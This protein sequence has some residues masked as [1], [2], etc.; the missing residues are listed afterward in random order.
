MYSRHGAARLYIL[1]LLLALLAPASAHAFKA[2][3]HD[4]A[5]LG[6]VDVR[7]DDRARPSA[8]AG[9]ARSVLESLLG[10]EGD[11]RSDR[12]TGALSFIGRTDGFLT[13]PSARSPAEVVL[14][15]LRGHPAS[16]GLDADDIDALELG[17][18]DVS[19]DGSTHLRWVQVVDGIRSLDSGV[20]AHVDTRGRLIS[21]SGSPLPDLAIDA[22][23]RRLT[24]LEALAAARRDVHGSA[25]PPRPRSRGGDELRTDFSTGEAARL[26]VFPTEDGGRLAWRVLVD[27]EEDL[28]YE[29]TID[30]ASGAVL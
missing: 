16:I 26:V 12:R 4:H 19:P 29:S 21:V 30:A 2:P 11:V 6:N 22:G 23:A 20:E 24:A 9:R 15:Y 7:S 1:V 28:A 25:L 17:A 10:R 8:R 13:G 3:R 18:S 5:A 27:G 14:D